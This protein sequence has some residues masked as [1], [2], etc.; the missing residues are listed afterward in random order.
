MTDALGVPHYFYNLKNCSEADF[1]KYTESYLK[2]ITSVAKNTYNYLL[3]TS[4]VD[5]LQD[6]CD[7]YRDLE[8]MDGLELKLSLLKSAVREGD[9]LLEKMSDTREKFE[10]SITAINEASNNLKTAE[11]HLIEEQAGIVKQ[12]PKTV[13]MIIVFALLSLS[14]SVIFAVLVSKRQYGAVDWTK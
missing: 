8:T 4:L 3:P 1:K 10:K 13:K 9:Q 6:L 5:E 2:S 12:D 7:H 11:N 14:L